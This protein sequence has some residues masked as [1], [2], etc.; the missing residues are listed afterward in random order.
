VKACPISAITKR[1]KDGIVVIDREKCIGKDECGCKCLKVCPWDSPQFSNKLNAK[2]EKCD[3]CLD[4]L[5]KGQQT[6]CVESCPM[7]A[8]NV[9]PMEDLQEK[10]GNTTKAEGFLNNDKI[11]PS[12]LLKPKKEKKFLNPELK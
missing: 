3:L 5:E 6:I 12:I 11:K 2:M 4:R 9:G 7:Y 1:E 8:L 10:Y